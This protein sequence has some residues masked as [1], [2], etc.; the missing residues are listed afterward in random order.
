[1]PEKKLGKYS[2]L[3][4]APTWLTMKSQRVSHT[5]WGDGDGNR[6]LGENNKEWKWN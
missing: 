1:M 4:I 2:P 6:K 3:S 5:D